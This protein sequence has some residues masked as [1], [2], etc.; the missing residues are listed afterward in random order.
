MESLV[1]KTLGQYQIV[2]EIGRGGMAVVYKAYQPSLTRYVAIKVLPQQF[3]FDHE[4]VERFAREARSAARLHHPNIVTI[5]DVSEQDGLHYFVMEY[6][7]GRTLDAVLADKPMP[8]PRVAHILDQVAAALDHAHAQSMIHRDIKPT[9]IMVDEACND[10]VV[11]MDF[12]LV[13]AGQDAKLTQSG[14]II[15]TP[16]YISP[17]QAQGEEVDYRTDI[18]SLGV[19]LYKMVTGAAPFVRA[20]PAAVLLAHVVYDPPSVSQI[21]RRVPR[22]VEAVV[23]KAMAKDR[24]QRYQSAGQ[25]ARDLRVAITG[26]MPVSLKVSSP[27]SPRTPTLAAAPVLDAPSRAAATIQVPAS[28]VPRKSGGISP[29]IFVGLGVAALAMLCVLAAVL[30]GPKLFPAGVGIGT[31]QVEPSPSAS[32]T[33]LAAPGPKGPAD[34]TV[35]SQDETITLAWE[36]AFDLAADEFYVLTLDCASSS[37]GPQMVWVKDKSY[38]VPSALYS[39]LSAPQQCHWNVV[40]MQQTGTDVSGARTGVGCSAP[41]STWRFSWRQV[42]ATLVRQATATLATTLTPVPTLTPTRRPPTNTPPRP[43]NT[44]APTPTEKPD[45]DQPGGDGGGGKDPEPPPPP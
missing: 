45:V 4:F 44:P 18:Y 6:L 41:S 37:S 40:V 24:S 39:S 36:A 33:L 21:N 17:E 20:T 1:G 7:T 15:G 22:S 5:H 19:V 10:H 30:A 26:Q 14:M 2:E 28:L 16:E 9:N 12:G 34:G 27:T 13:R 32:A 23:H 35:F 43:T 11:L 42:T 25:L 3:S 31:P 8:L 38:T 29:L